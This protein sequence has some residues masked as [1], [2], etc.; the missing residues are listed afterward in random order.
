MHT[1]VIN[2]FLLLVTILTFVEV[3]P[4]SKFEQ[5]LI[6]P[7]RQNQVDLVPY[8]QNSINTNH[9]IVGGIWNDI[10][11][12]V[13]D[14]INSHLSGLS[15]PGCQRTT[16]SNGDYAEYC[17]EKILNPD[18]KSYSTKTS[19]ILYKSDGTMIPLHEAESAIEIETYNHHN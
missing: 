17:L 10:K 2:L 16:Y 15:K 19:E 1:L 9:Q 14:H 11:N 4:L 12:V 5:N 8:Q 7:R 6:R 18:G 13:D 3:L